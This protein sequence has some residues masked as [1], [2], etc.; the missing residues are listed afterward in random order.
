MYL[1]NYH[2]TCV[3]TK[4]QRK[5]QKTFPVLPGLNIAMTILA[6]DWFMFF[7]SFV[8]YSH[9]ETELMKTLLTEREGNKP[10]KPPVTKLAK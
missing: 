8:Q 1:K 9:T 7:F 10:P 2:A 5:L 6:A 4:L 3:E